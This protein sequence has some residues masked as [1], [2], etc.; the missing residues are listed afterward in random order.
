[1]LGEIPKTFD[2]TPLPWHVW[3]TDRDQQTRYVVLLGGTAATIPGGASAR[4]HLFD[5]SG[6]SIDAWSFNVGWRIFLY[7]ASFEYSTALASNLIVLHTAKTI[8]GRDVA[9]EILAIDKDRPLLVRLENSKG[10][11]IPN[12]Y[13]ISEIEVNVTPNAKSVE[14]FVTL[15]ESSDKADVLSALVFLG[16]R[17]LDDP[18]W[19]RLPG[20]HESKYA[21]VFQEVIGDPRIQASIMRLTMSD[22]DWIKQAARLAA[23]GP[24]DR[25]LE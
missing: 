10:E 4:V 7:D 9:K 16:G 19:I 18:R 12:E 6:K 21:A 15:L 3:R 11:T 1:M 13:I 14:V 8:N 25:L 17:H 23:R 2:S 20:P 5:R 22:N 24:R